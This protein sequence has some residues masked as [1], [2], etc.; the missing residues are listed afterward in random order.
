MMN[1]ENKKNKTQKVYDFLNLIFGDAAQF[2]LEHRIFTI[3]CFFGTIIGIAGASVNFILNLGLGV[4][5]LLLA[6]SV[7]FGVFYYFSRFRHK[8]RMLI[9]PLVIIVFGFLSYN[10][11][12]NGG[13]NGPTLF[14]FMI[15]L[16]Y[17]LILV[18][19]KSIFILLSILFATISV[20]LLMEYRHPELITTY[21][22]RL[23]KFL[24]IFSTFFYG[25]IFL[26]LGISAVMNR[27][28]EE[29]KKTEEER[30]K[31]DELL[32]NIL[33][34]EIAEE[35]KLKGYSLPV[36]YDSVTIMFTDFK[37][38]TL[39]AETMSPGKLV[40]EL[41]NCF[42]YFD[43]VSERYNLEKLKTIGDS[44][45]C[46]GGIPLPGRAH[47]VDAVLAALEIQAFM[48]Q[49]K[50]IKT[51]QNLPYWE[52]RLGIHTGP[53]VA[54]VIGDKK[55]AYDVWGDTVN[56]ASRMESSGVEGKINISN[57]TFK[58]VKSFFNC[59][60]R[61]RVP[62]KHKGEVDMHFVNGI[63]P[64]LSKNGDGRV[65][66]ET[67]NEMYNELNYFTESEK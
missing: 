51:E 2:I 25:I 60:Y 34:R 20:L 37:G 28:Y 29:K 10:W 4:T 14:L 40:E 17:L 57:A 1:I 32:L 7:A 56:T 22:N 49:T 62:A 12:L 53:L 67:F 21:D 55:F 16:S 13:I 44:F 46:A 54:G 6:T 35:L 26:A 9:W 5:F 33:P 63:R 41:D 52:L 47:A 45:M 31:A 43:A 36:H 61:G 50:A 8:F 38:F 24:D 15:T 18:R 64:E 48:N 42:S 23:V 11:F 66:N 3:L 30:N 65:P 39:V 59:D 19:G 27:Y 58:L